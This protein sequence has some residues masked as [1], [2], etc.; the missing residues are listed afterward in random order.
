MYRVKRCKECGDE[1]HIHYHDRRRIV[2]NTCEH[3]KHLQGKNIKESDYS[4]YFRKWFYKKGEKMNARIVGK[5]FQYSL[6]SRENNKNSCKLLK[7]DDE[8]VK[9][10]YKEIPTTRSIDGPDVT[11]SYIIEICTEDC[12]L[13][14]DEIVKKI[15][16]IAN[17]IGF[18]D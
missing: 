13:T 5:V 18:I 8:F 1:I 10:I 17:E 3:L 15:D 16:S 7:D 9:R 6:P 4:K 12:D 2:R 11:G 14:D